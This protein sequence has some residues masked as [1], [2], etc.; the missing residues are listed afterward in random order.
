MFI[1]QKAATEIYTDAVV[2]SVRWVEETGLLIF[3]LGRA[4][5]TP[6]ARA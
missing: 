3:H 1:Q 2:G 5:V 4:D 6:Y